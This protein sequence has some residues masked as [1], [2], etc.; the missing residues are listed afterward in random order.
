MV[1]CVERIVEVKKIIFVIGD[2]KNGGLE[3]RVT[4]LS[5]GFAD[6]GYIVDI[7]VTQ[8]LSDSIFFRLNENVRII[9]K[10]EIEQQEEFSSNIDF[11]KKEKQ[12]RK[13]KKMK[14]F[15]NA[16][17]RIIAFWSK[18]TKRHQFIRRRI[19]KRYIS[20][21]KIIDYRIKY[22]NRFLSFRQYFISAKPDIVIFVAM[23]HTDVIAA[24]EGMSCR[25]FY[26]EVIA[27]EKIFPIPYHKEEYEY[28]YNIFLKFH[29]L[30][31][32]TNEAKNFYDKKGFKNVR[33]IHNPIKQ[34][35]PPRFVGN[36]RKVIVNFCRVSPQKNIFL[37]LEAFL[38]FHNEFRDYTVEIYGNITFESEK[39]YKETILR[40]V[41]ELNLDDYFKILPSIADIHE[42]VLDAAMFVSS[43]DYEGI[44][45]S[46]LE[47]MAIGLPCI[48]TDCLGGGTREVMVNH[49]N[50]IIV[51]IND[52][53]AMYKAMKIFAENS[54][55]AEECGRNAAKIREELS[56]DKITKKWLEVLNS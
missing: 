22:L 45:N 53:E 52:S 10:K 48:C 20:K 18:K 8:E 47:A 50:G 28:Y 39:K 30:I 43:S 27:P 34:Y 15:V 26:N 24:V 35:L 3:R 25:L 7:L 16:H 44:S 9:S 40:K 19:K 42:K 32:Q 33:V 17:L 54:D 2:Y 51:P 5:N 55:F 56:N 36:R 41:H 46:M 29:G 21:E 11:S 23:L 6:N 14:K 13:L 31:V 38:K 12:L 49:V 1:K 4:N 37:L